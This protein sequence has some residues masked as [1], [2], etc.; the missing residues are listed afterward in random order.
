MTALNQ[1][2]ARPDSPIRD[3]DEVAISPPVTGG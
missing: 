3:D 2:M 1:E